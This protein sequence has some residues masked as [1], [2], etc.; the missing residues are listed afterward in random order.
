[1]TKRSAALPPAISLFESGTDGIATTPSALA[2]KFANSRG[3]SKPSDP[4]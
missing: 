1:M 4:P 3:S 2:T